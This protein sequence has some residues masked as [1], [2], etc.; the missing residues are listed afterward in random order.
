MIYS[1]PS[2]RS[3]L[4]MTAGIA[5]GVLSSS[6][7]PGS[8]DADT[9]DIPDDPYPLPPFDYGRLPAAFRRTIVP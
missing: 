4:A 8:A 3:L 9:A 6:G 1:R 7:F 2:R 5:V